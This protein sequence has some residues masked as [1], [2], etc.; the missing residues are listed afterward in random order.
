MLF[1]L[2]VWTGSSSQPVS[3]I[4]SQCLCN[5][6]IKY[7]NYLLGPRSMSG[8][9]TNLGCLSISAVM[10]RI[11]DTGNGGASTCG[12]SIK[13]A[14]TP[15]ATSISTPSVINHPDLDTSQCIS[16]QRCSPQLSSP[17][18][19]CVS[20]SSWRP[21]LPPLMLGYVFIILSMH[22]TKSTNALLPI[23]TTLKLVTL[24]LRIVLNR[25]V[26]CT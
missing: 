7:R 17:L 22:L 12:W 11:R 13:T 10:V 8:C 23:H 18:P 9:V 5:S 16:H 20:H 6:C 25:N 21:Y 4:F 2:L 19:C 15:Q 3:T 26:D 24:E 14:S 1:P